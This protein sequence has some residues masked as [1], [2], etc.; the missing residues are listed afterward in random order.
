[1][2]P[3]DGVF[4]FSCTQERKW[5]AYS[6][7]TM[8]LL[9]TSEPE[10]PWNYY[11]MGNNIYDGK[12]LT[13]GYS[14]ILLAYNI[15]TG[16]IVWNYTAQ[17]VGLESWYGNTPISGTWIVDGKIY[18]CSTEHSPSMPYRRDAMIR[19][20]DADTG[21]QLWNV[22]HWAINLAISDGY[23]VALNYY[24]NSIYCYGIGSSATTVTA[25]PKVSV[26][27]D[28]VLVE[29]TVTDDSP[30]GKQDSSGNVILPLKGTPAIADEC[31]GQ[32][33]EYLFAQRPIPS[34]AEGVEVS[35]DTLD[36]NG[37]FVHI[38]NT[39][40]DITGKFAFAFTPEVPGTYQI[41][42]TFAGSKSYGPSSANTYITVDEAPAAIAEPTP[43]PPTMAELYFM[44]MSVG[45]I[46]AIAAVIALLA[47]LLLR[48]R[49]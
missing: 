25:N 5:Y 4:L 34:N 28:T 13:Y 46:I 8:D 39:T 11:G 35:L 22:T 3:E 24:D 47:L 37:N 21:R 17:T 27:G 44:P 1:V 2:D 20:I 30:G 36:P 15:T 45:M 32:W 9:W 16:K 26:H 12:L 48:K 33:M 41:I 42:A 49:T 23:L 29:G 7:D 14:G 6:M 31:M 18:I 40:S 10:S 38:G 43:T 19:C